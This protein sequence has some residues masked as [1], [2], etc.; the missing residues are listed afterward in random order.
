MHPILYFGNM[1]RISVF[2]SSKNLTGFTL[3]ARPASSFVIVCVLMKGSITCTIKGV[4]KQ[5]FAKL[6]SRKKRLSL[7]AK[8][9]SLIAA[10]SFDLVR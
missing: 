5:L 10:Q 7:L 6:D 2:R 1:F 8:E 4:E 3:P 9:S